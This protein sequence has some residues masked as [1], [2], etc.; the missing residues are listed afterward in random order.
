MRHVIG[1]IADSRRGR[2]DRG[3]GIGRLSG[4]LTYEATLRFAT[5][6]K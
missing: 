5:I 6:F 3:E 1:E 4:P 2:R